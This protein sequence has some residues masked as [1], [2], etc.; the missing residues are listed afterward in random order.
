MT[1][2]SGALCVAGVLIALPAS[3]Q[4]PPVPSLPLSEY[5]SEARAAVE[6]AYQA[7][8][9]RPSD[10]AAVGALARIL[11]AWHELDAAHEAY[12]R[13]QVLAPKTF[14]WWYLDGIVL[15]RLARHEDAAEQF[16]RALE[17]APGYLPAQVKL[18]ESVL[19]NG[20]LDESRRLFQALLSD[21]LAEAFGQFG[22]GQIAASEGRHE[23]AIGHLQRAVALFPEWGE[24]HYALAMSYVA[25]KRRE[26]AT[27]ARALHARHA[28]IVPALEDPILTATSSIRDDAVASLERGVTLKQA[29]DLGGAIAAHE[30]AVARDPSYA[31]AHANLITLYGEASNW[32]KVEEH[33][34][35]VVSLGFGLADANYDYGRALELQGKWAEAEAA[36]QRT[37]KINSAHTGAH[38]NLG[39]LLERQRRFEAAADEFR[40]AV[41]SQPTDR[42]ARYDLGRMLLALGKPGEAVTEFELTLE[43]R[44]DKTPASLLGLAVAHAVAGQPQEASRRFDEAKALA[45]SYGL[46]DMVR[47]I[48]EARVSFSGARP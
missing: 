21:R 26:E 18:A 19:K 12:R 38:I 35:A 9:A 32:P 46:T 16:R 34:R 5:P 29:G 10:A 15:Q 44:D 40:L 14:D 31:Q 36:Y 4:A 24:A 6:P 1:A 47:A 23:M 33:Y 43:P 11:Q 27:A 20:N 17:V 30:E 42:V 7:A 45:A 37:T 22:L 8:R 3:A 25:L 39:R 48:D 2:W 41:A 13:A 28:A